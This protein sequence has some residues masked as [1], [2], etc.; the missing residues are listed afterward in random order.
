MSLEI[1][2]QNGQLYFVALDSIID[3][4]LGNEETGFFNMSKIG[5]ASGVGVK[6]I[7]NVVKK[8]AKCQKSRLGKFSSVVRH[9]VM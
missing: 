8:G 1:S 7:A 5:H 6:T 9:L 4:I 2:S 3:F